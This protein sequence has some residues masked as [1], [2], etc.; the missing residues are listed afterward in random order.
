MLRSSILSIAALAVLGTV[1][2]QAQQAEIIL[3]PR[4]GHGQIQ[5]QSDGLTS[6][7]VAVTATVFASREHWLGVMCAPVDPALRA[8]L[9]LPEKQGLLVM[10]V[11][12]DSPAAKAGILQHDILL[13][14]GE[15]SL[16]NLGDLPKAVEAAKKSAKPVE[17]IR[18]GKRQTVEVAPGKRPKQPQQLHNY[19]NPASA[20]DWAVVQHWLEGMKT[21]SA[22]AGRG[23]PPVSFHL[24]HPS[25]IFS[26]TMGAHKPMPDDLSVI[27]SKNGDKPA[28][29][30][31]RRG[32]DS[33]KVSE[34]DLNKLPKNI[35]P[36]IARMLGHGPMLVGGMAK[37]DAMPNVLIADVTEGLC[38][39]PG[40]QGRTGAHGIIVSQLPQPDQV[41][42]APRPGLDPRLEQRFQEMNRR[43]DRMLK[44]MEQMLQDHLEQSDE[45]N[46]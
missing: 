45:S 15:Q 40:G 13:S 10:R 25:A 35:R 11:L 38:D 29:I 39:V 36:Y 12:P 30:E 27:I 41:R 22:V 21:G 32:K 9:N 44:M 23:R 4:Q 31:I 19:T 7:A 24:V 20:D 5:V 46:D 42:F 8:Q 16:G 2:A 17:L 33:W 26:G 14:F 34:N 6:R 18:S 43:M 28:Q 37:L 1:V 3:S